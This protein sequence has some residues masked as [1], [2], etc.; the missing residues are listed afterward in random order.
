MSFFTNSTMQI[1]IGMHGEEILRSYLKTRKV[2]FMQVDLIVENGDKI[3]IIEVKTQEKYKAP[4]YDGHGLPEHQI[5]SRINIAEK[6][7]MI[8]YLYVYDLHDKFFYLQ[9][10]RI[11]MAGKKFY[12]KTGSRVI[13]PLSNF[14]ILK[15]NL[16]D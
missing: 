9:D 6:T 13:F 12:T 3:Y 7:G 15:V 4:P 5:M 2:K 16:S 1:E 10:M 14:E 8:P 11:L